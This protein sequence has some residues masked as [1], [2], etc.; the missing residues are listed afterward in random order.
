MFW[1]FT[2]HKLVE[3]VNVLQHACNA[4]TAKLLERIQ[5][6]Y[7]MLTCKRVEI[8]ARD[9]KGLGWRDVDGML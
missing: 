8:D 5:Q 6:G 7:P 4:H 3:R 2:W 1:P 9:T